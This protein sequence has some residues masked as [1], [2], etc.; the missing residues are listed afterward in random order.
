MR[1]DGSAA[2]RTVAIRRL[3]IANRG[4]IAVRVV[5]ACRDLGVEA[6][7]A[8]SEADRD[9]MAVKM[10]DRGICI[11]PAASASSYLNIAGLVTAAA[12]L[13]CDAIHPGYGFLAE[14]AEFAAACEEENII[15]VGPRSETIAL[16]GDKIAARQTAQRLDVPVIPGSSSDVADIERARSTG[17]SIGFPLLI[18][19]GGGGGG[20]GLR[21][22]ESLD[23]LELSL[24]SAAGEA[25]LAFGNEALYIE[26]FIARARHIEVQ[27]AA[28][29]HGHVLHFGERDCSV[30][31]NYQKLVEEAPSPV[32]DADARNRIAETA[33]RLL[34]GV[35]YRGVGTVEFLLDQDSGHFYFIEVNTRIQVEHPVTEMVTGHDLIT[36]Q[37]RLAGGAQLSLEQQDIGMHGHA[38]EFRIN[39]EDPDVDFRP[40]AGRIEQWRSP[41]GPGVRVDTHC[42]SGYEVPPF[43]DSLLAKLILYG[44]TREEALRR[45]RRAFEEYVVVGVEST[46]GFHRWLLENED[47]ATGRMHTAWVAQQWKGSGAA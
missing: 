47:F 26:K 21:L 4:E 35:D 28:D 11:G 14:N 44:A 12:A 41:E 9:S 24:A 6:V 5:R 20:R 1:A 36:L 30:Q 8:F 17:E 32:I 46:V 43:Y 3:L 2:S 31:R 16:L 25:R 23:E 22:V 7:V 13:G 10:A 38:I 40:S 27:I 19:A 15:F 45:A 18:K 29:E 39:A 42:F 33:V 34:K 37:L